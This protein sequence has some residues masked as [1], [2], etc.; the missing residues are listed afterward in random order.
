MAAQRQHQAPQQQAMI[1]ERP[2]RQRGVGGGGGRD[3]G[4]LDQNLVGSGGQQQFVGQS[5]ASKSA[6][7][8]EAF[9]GPPPQ[10]PLYGTGM[11]PGGGGTGMGIGGSGMGMGSSSGGGGVSGLGPG[12]GQQQQSGRSPPKRRQP[13]SLA[14]S[15]VREYYNLM[16]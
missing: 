12:G 5:M 13:M 16:T 4:F 14:A 3:G 11:R 7:S 6:S 10:Q 15:D 8:R 2:G 1:F 9:D